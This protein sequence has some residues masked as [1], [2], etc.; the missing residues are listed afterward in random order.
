MLGLAASC[1]FEKCRRLAKAYGIDHIHLGGDDETREGQTTGVKQWL[2]R[3]AF[4]SAT[5]SHGD[6]LSFTDTF[7]IYDDA[8]HPRWRVYQE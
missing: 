4:A 3:V 8:D 6:L 7:D 2:G 1:L 5:L